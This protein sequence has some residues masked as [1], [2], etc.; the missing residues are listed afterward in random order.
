VF[1]Q[2]W[3][4]RRDG[5]GYS[6]LQKTENPGRRGS[7]GRGMDI[8]WNHTL[9]NNYVTNCLTVFSLNLENNEISI[10]GKEEKYAKSCVNKKLITTHAK[11][12]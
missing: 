6:L 10:T 1:V 9:H 2:L 11:L 5:G 8:F 3:K 7:R 12:S 4:I